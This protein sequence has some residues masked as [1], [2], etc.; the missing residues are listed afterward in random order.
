MKPSP[1]AQVIELRPKV[2]TEPLQHVAVRTNHPSAGRSAAQD[3]FAK[4]VQLFDWA[5]EP[6]R[7]SLPTLQGLALDRLGTFVCSPGLIT[8]EQAIE[9]VSVLRAYFR[10]DLDEAPAHGIARPQLDGAS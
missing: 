2:T 8:R 9:A 10:P 1:F 7:P 5:A 6:D 4:I 3:E